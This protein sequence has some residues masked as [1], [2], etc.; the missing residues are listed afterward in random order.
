MRVFN[1][2]VVIIVIL[3]AMPVSTLLLVMPDLTTVALSEVFAGLAERVAG[4][5]QQFRLAMALAALVIDIALLLLLYLELRRKPTPGG[6]VTR[7]RG[8]EGEVSLEAIRQRVHHHVSQLPDVVEVKPAV[9][10]KGGRVIVAL[11]VVTSP[12]VNVPKKLDEIVQVVR[13]SVTGGMGL[14]LRGKPS[15]SIRH[16]AYSKAPSPRSAPASLS[17]SAPPSSSASES[18]PDAA[19]RRKPDIRLKLPWK[20]GS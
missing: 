1:K 20:P 3:V 11:D 19:P 7:V 4:L 16:V 9:S 18:A 13:E 6:K 12:H 2:V 14:K 15:V 5:E 10:A 17:T 8:G